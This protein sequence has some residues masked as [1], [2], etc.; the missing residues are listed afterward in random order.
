MAER[1]DA[2]RPRRSLYILEHAAPASDQAKR[3]HV[4]VE[5]QVAHVARLVDD[6]LD[7]T[8]VAS[9]KLQI[10]RERLELVELV[11]RAVEDHRALFAA[12]GIE[13]RASVTTP[14]AWAQ[15]DPTRLTQVVGNLLQNAAKFTAEG[16]RVE[17]SLSVNAG[18][19]VLRLS[20]TGMGIP[21]EMLERV[22]EPFVQ[23]EQALDRHFGGLGLGLA[24]A[25]GIVERHGGEI[26]ATSDGPGR[27]AV[28]TVR[29][30]V[31]ASVAP[32]PTRI[33]AAQ[34]RQRR[35]LIIEDNV[36]AA[37]TLRDALE[38]D[39]H[40]VVVANDGAQ[41]IEAARRF[42]PEVVLCDVGL[43]RMDGYEVARVFRADAALRSAFLV[44]VTGYALAEDISRALE[45]G[46]DRH[47]AKPVSVDVLERALDEAQIGSATADHR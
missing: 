42:L 30:P 13:L 41:G 19:A 27:G 12:G 28:F 32:E 39:G 36:D 26:R 11:R 29:L 14:P 45:A 43:P 16:G 31:D 24:L 37:D 23:T 17:V 6:L 33:S 1:I 3:A 44:A 7:A 18:N 4:V 35:V 38:L 40:T 15:G 8:R 2:L 5:R 34:H 9:G 47:L 25:K 46:F 10:R 21:P 22:F 20:D